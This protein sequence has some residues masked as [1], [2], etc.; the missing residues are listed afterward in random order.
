MATVAQSDMALGQDFSVPTPEMQPRIASHGV[1]HQPARP[2]A[3]RPIILLMNP[4]VVV[5]N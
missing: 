3:L 2:A 4:K 1:L 5:L